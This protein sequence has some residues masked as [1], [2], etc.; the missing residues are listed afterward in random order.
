MA[1]SKIQAESMNLADTYAFSGTVSGTSVAGSA[2][3]CARTTVDDWQS[4]SNETI[5]LFN[6]VSTGDCFDTDG[7]YNTSTYK[8]TAPANGVY[9]FWYSVYTAM[10]DADNGFT[11]LK[12]STKVNF[13]RVSSDKFITFNGG[14]TADH[15]QNG[16]I[17]IPLASG[18]TM[19]VV[20]ATQSDYYKA[21]C[22]WGGCRLA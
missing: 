1:L 8:F 7:V 19:A 4:A 22:Q 17:I 10:N 20:A 3:F 6:D 18:N 21:R 11:F 13:S 14:E 2:A 5:I 15:I 16:T 12:N 9:M